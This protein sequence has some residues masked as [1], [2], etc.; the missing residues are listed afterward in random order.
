MRRIAGNHRKKVV[1]YEN[2][3]AGQLKQ[4]L[5]VQ[6][7]N[8]GHFPDRNEGFRK[9]G[10][11]WLP[12]RFSGIYTTARF[13]VKLAE[14]GFK[15]RALDGQA[16]SSRQM[17]LHLNGD[18]FPITERLG[19]DLAR[20]C[21]QSRTGPTLGRMFALSEVKPQ[22]S[23]YSTLSTMRFDA[24]CG[25]VS[26]EWKSWTGRPGSWRCETGRA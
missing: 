15:E 2:P 20:I 22:D 4:N 5:S 17:Y 1:C 8:A 13:N 14:T 11:G 9:T 26:V 3:Q 18:E 25:Y 24:I 19:P 7:W 21:F 10:P 12:L 16:P 6:G 23:G